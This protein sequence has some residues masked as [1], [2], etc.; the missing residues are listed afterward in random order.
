MR[1]LWPEPRADVEPYDAYRL[2]DPDR[3]WLRLDMVTSLDGAVADAEGRSG[4]L[5][6][7][8]DWAV[9]LA[10][11]ALADAVLV[12]AGTVRAEGYGPHRLRPG[13]AERRAADGRPGPA[14]IVVVSRSLE[15]DTSAPLFTEA[16][17]P[18]VVLTC[19][20]APGDRQ[21]AVR[22]AGRLVVAGDEDVDLAEGLARLR[23]D[24]LVQ[25]VCEG[26]PTLNRAL[27]AAGLVDELDVTLAPAL[28][29][30]GRPGAQ[31][32][33]GT[34]AERVDLALVQVGQADDELFLRYRVRR[35]LQRRR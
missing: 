11:R 13:L 6:G 22:R 21:A 4:S 19:A 10:L 12:G 20:A 32:L 34:L 1:L 27:L 18:T 24:G 35:G 17:T 16:V 2:D 3:P 31:G 28:V 7:E 8:G 15:L 33:A 9:F 29:Q 30:Q 14:A 26:G 25:L 5:G 23:A